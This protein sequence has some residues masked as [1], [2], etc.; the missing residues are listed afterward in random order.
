MNIRSAKNKG[1]RLQIKVQNMLFERTEKLGLLPGDITNTM[2]SE[3]GRDIKLSPLA[4][5]V[6]PFDIECKNREVISITESL[7]QA[8]DNSK[9]GRIP[10]LIFKKNRSDIYSILAYNSLKQN[11]IENI[12]DITDKKR[13][14]IWKIILDC[15]SKYDSFIILIKKN[16]D[17]YCVIQFEELLNIFYGLKRL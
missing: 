10:L 9:S 12:L 17:V 5:T 6:I 15:E 14:N 1:K 3:N 11:S 2:A 8:N 13:Y 16:N 4:E 7:I